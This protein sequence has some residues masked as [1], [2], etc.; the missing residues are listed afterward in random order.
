VKSEVRDQR[1]EVRNLKPALLV[2]H[3]GTL[4][5]VVLAFPGLIL[6]KKTFPRID[7]LCRNQIGK[8][9]VALGIVNNCF[10]LEG[11]VFTALYS[12]AADT[13][14]AE[15]LASYRE[16]LL[17]SSSL[18]LEHTLSAV[19]GKKVHR[20]SPRPRIPLKIHV[21]D[22]ILD[23]LSAC[24]LLQEA[25]SVRE[26]PSIPF[27]DFRD[28]SFDGKRILLHPG[29]GSPRKNWPLSHFMEL[30]RLLRS[31]G[32]APEFILGPAEDLL[33]LGLEAE[34]DLSVET[35][36]DL[37]RLSRTLRSAGGFVGNDSGPT[38]LAAFLGL[39][40]VAV[41]G[42]SDPV[43]WKPRG[44][45][46]TVVGPGIDCAPCLES[47]VKPCSRWDCLEK[48]L[49]QEVYSAFLSAYGGL[50]S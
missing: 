43:R 27:T 44:L 11:R 50:S 15:I 24:G 33:A 42:P 21:T 12:G 22:H 16:I 10:A 38:H 8:L 17:F 7:L 40:T 26:T 2:I 46:V 37:R 18:E 48:T 6:L 5:D 35:V 47:E 19:Y 39:P 36:E 4:G 32:L 31:G 29:S 3:H 28:T 9:A 14:V 45:R 20:V 41:F 49:P 34:P 23:A 30:H 13:Q 1:S 25:D